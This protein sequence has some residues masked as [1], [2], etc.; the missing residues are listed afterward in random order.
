MTRIITPTFAKS[1]LVIL[2]VGL[3]ACGC[4]AEPPSGTLELGSEKEEFEAG[5]DVKV[6]FTAANVPKDAWIGVIP[7]DVEHGDADRNDDHDVSYK[8]LEGKAK[9][10]MT[11]KAPDEAGEYDFRLN[12]KDDKGGKEL[13]SVSFT[14]KE[15]ESKGKLTLKKKTFK[16]GEEIKLTFK[17]PKGLPDNAWIGL[18]P[19]DVPHGDADKNDDHDVSY[20]YLKGKTKGSMTFNAPSKAGKYDLRLNNQDNTGGKELT[21]V[22]FTVE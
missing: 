4:K 8:Y 19:S 9:G 21:S 22:S 11:F 12:E 13:A 14:V 20:K 5:A 7:S 1:L 15:D 18:I 17:A 16:T 10:T 3:L 2:G 6:K